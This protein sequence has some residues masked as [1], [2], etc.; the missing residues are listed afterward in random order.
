[1]DPRQYLG[2]VRRLGPYPFILLN[3]LL[4]FQAAHTAPIVMMSQNCQAEHDGRNAENDYRINVK[5]ELE[6]ELL[7][8]KID[9][10]RKQEMMELINSV[11]TLE[12][13]LARPAG[14]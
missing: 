7:H 11:L 2:L 9:L 14:G 13:R 10:L 6:I 1:M 12:G 5:A 4:S 3:L 8:Q